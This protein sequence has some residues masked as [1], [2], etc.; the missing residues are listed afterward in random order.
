[1]ILFLTTASQRNVLMSHLGQEPKCKED[2]Y[3]SR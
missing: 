2:F 1:M 3:H